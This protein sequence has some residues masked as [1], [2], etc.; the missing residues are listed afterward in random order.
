MTK[1]DRATY[2]REYRARRKAAAETNRTERLTLQLTP[3]EVEDLNRYFRK[4]FR[5]YPDH[6]GLA[7]MVRREL[8]MLVAWDREED[9][10]EEWQE[11]SE[12]ER[13][14]TPDPTPEFNALADACPSSSC[15][16]PV[17]SVRDAKTWRT[18]AATG[19]PQWSFRSG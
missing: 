13:E 8:R 12:A 18:C 19:E 2:M 4:H 5:S 11:L 1:R 15:R 16:C 6:S 9:A 10:F 14:A 7:D 3:A 17:H